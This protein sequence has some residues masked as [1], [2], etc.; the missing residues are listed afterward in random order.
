VRVLTWNLYHGRSRPGAGRSLL[1]EFTRALAGWE[2][3]V[4]LLQEVPPWWPPLLGDRLGA[5]HHTALT[6]RN[7]LLWLR[8]AIASRNPDLLK[9][10]GGGANAILVRSG[11]GADHRRELLCRLP[12]RRVAHGV[13]VDGVRVVNLHASLKPPERNRLDVEAAQSAAERWA[14]GN[15][16]VLGGDFNQRRLALPGMQVAAGPWVD[17][18]AV[19]G[20]AAPDRAEALDAGSLSDHEP[21][22]VALARPPRL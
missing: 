3:D 18:F 15:P 20:L 8:R 21:L 13:R 4:A 16:L 10:N 17:H 1:P 14:G 11:T 5:G 7:S 9:S 2:W 22:L 12:E 19:R 6:S